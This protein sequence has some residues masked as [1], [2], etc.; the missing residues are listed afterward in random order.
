V[1]SQLT[2]SDTAVG[3]TEHRDEAELRRG[4]RVS[5][6]TLRARAAVRLTG[7]VPVLH[8]IGVAAQARPGTPCVVVTPLKRSSERA[9][10][11]PSTLLSP[12][13]MNELN[14]DDRVSRL[15][16]ATRVARC[17]LP[18][19]D[20]VFCRSSSRRIYRSAEGP[21]LYRTIRWLSGTRAAEAGV[22]EKRLQQSALQVRSKCTGHCSIDYTCTHL[23][24]I[25]HLEHF[26]PNSISLVLR[27]IRGLYESLPAAACPPYSV[28]PCIPCAAD[29]TVHRPP[30]L[31]VACPGLA[32]V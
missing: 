10:L 18:A 4:H 29:C 16:A 8:P 11:P 25:L 2:Q 23:H 22:P 17:L 1:T 5:D 13:V 32:R 31:Y 30:A 28:V 6:A 26:P 20:L 27:L 24:V 7:R 19:L 9:R 12:Y 3:T 14:G 15:R 21:L